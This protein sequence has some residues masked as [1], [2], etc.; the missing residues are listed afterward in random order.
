MDYDYRNKSGPSY[1]RPPMY[2][3]PKI[4]QQSGHGLQFFS[5]PER[6][7]SSQHISSPFPSSSSSGLGIKVT[8]KPEYRITPPPQLLPRAGDIPRSGFQFDFGLERTVLAAGEKEN[9]DWSKFGSEN[10]PP[11][12]FPEPPAPSMGVDP[13]VMKYAAFGLN[14]EAVNIAVANYGDNPTKVQEFATGFT[15]IRE[16]GFPT[17]AVAEALFMFEN[18]TDKA[19]SHL[20]H[21]SS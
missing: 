6:N 16:M 4:G 12:K 1:G 3:Y 9:P 11:P 20:L 10:P 18:D 13:L 19:L 21:G 5:P 15:A 14:R 8:L 7:Q 17:N 2:G